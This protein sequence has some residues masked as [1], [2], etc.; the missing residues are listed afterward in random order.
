MDALM[1][2]RAQLKPLA[3]HY[4][5]AKFTLMPLMIKAVSLALAE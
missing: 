1:E 5:V 4:G 2:A 3:A